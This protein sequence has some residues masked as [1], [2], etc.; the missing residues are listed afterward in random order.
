MQCIF[1]ADDGNGVPGSD[2]TK[3]SSTSGWMN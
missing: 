2:T 3:S 1:E